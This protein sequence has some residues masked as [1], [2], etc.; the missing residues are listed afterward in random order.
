MTKCPYCGAVIYENDVYCEQCGK[1]LPEEMV[2]NPKDSEGAP[3]HKLHLSRVALSTVA[4]VTVLALLVSIMVLTEREKATDGSNNTI[5]LEKGF[6]K[7]KVFDESSALNVIEEVSTQLGIADTYKELKTIGITKVGDDVYYRFQQLC[8]G[9][10]VYGKTVALKVGK[11]NDAEVLASNTRRTNSLISKY[12]G[13]DYDKNKAVIFDDHICELNFTEKEGN[14]YIQLIDVK[15]HKIVKELCKTYSEDYFDYTQDGNVMLYDKTRN[16][17]VIDV[18]KKVLHKAF[19]PIGND[20]I[21]VYYLGKELDN[22]D[23]MKKQF[24]AKWSEH[25]QLFMNDSQ[26]SVSHHFSEGINYIT[27]NKPADINKRAVDIAQKVETVNDFFF[28]HFGR[29]GYDN[30][31]SKLYVA[32]NDGFCDGKNS[33][34]YTSV[35]LGF[36][37]N[38]DVTID[39]VAHEFTHSVEGVISSMDYEGESGALMEAYSDVFGELVEGDANQS[40]PDW[41]HHTYSSSRN[42]VSPES[43][44]NPAKYLGEYWKSTKNETDSRGSS[45][46]DYGNVHNNSTVFSHAAYLMS[47]GIDGTESRKIDLNTLAD[48]WY[49]SFFLLTSDSSLSDAAKVVYQSAATLGTLSGSQLDCVRRAFAD[50]GI[51][52]AD[53]PTDY[54]VGKGSELSVVGYDSNPLSSYYLD[55]KNKS[56]NKMIFQG[57][58]SI[59]KPYQIDLDEGEYDFIIKTNPKSLNEYKYSVVVNGVRNDKT[60]TVRIPEREGITEEEV[61]QQYLQVVRDYEQK[62]GI[63]TVTETSQTGLQAGELVDLNRDGIKELVLLYTKNKHEWSVPDTCDVWAI[64][65]GKAVLSGTLGTSVSRQSPGY[66]EISI[67]HRDGVTMIGIVDENSD[68]LMEAIF[69]IY[70]YDG[71]KMV[72]AYSGSIKPEKYDL[73]NP[74][75]TNY[76]CMINNQP[77]SE[78][79]FIK[80]LDSIRYGKKV[81]AGI[82]TLS[83]NLL[84]AASAQSILRMRIEELKKRLGADYS[85]EDT[86]QTTSGVLQTDVLKTIPS[87]YVYSSGAGAWR[88]YLELSS[89]GTFKGQFSD[90]EAS[91]SGDGFEKGTVYISNFK[92]RF[93]SPTK[94]SEMI[95][96]FKLESLEVEGEDGDEYFKND[97]KYIVCD[98]PMGFENAEVFKVFYPGCPIS[99]IP[100]EI[101]EWNHLD[102]QN[103]LP[104][105]TYILCNMNEKVGFVSI[106]EVH[107]K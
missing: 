98:P 68:I 69:N 28:D 36:G 26:H 78:E 39:L 21:F 33:Y 38:E 50:V 82:L 52:H 71:K 48:I 20:G 89:D 103:V 87:K 59:D 17:K 90:S 62:Y 44:K 86:T 95:S 37:Y 13:I 57:V 27:R 19:E 9:I 75:D 104:Q 81:S 5:L 53:Y 61:N 77:V 107:Y 83:D 7:I 10:P 60:I 64:Q 42:M 91:L 14:S 74:D 18:N 65:N 67:I 6:S 88:T 101:V 93:S 70:K 43:S 63:A 54:I 35:L 58:I 2:D 4:V 100:D 66:E 79:S 34:S 1:K 56:S 49:R 72:N 76:S 40:Q 31:Q 94:D 29:K 15:D 30:H 80:V 55:I 25:E 84:D 102:T 99:S 24:S 97:Q 85:N 92:G 45:K 3:H 32:Y 51:N 23:A 106:D 41:I 11:E 73:D 47:T 96:S 46:N 22:N 8:D 105:N 16:I 12:Q